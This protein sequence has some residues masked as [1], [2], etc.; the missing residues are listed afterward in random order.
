M[1]GIK[2][3]LKEA[4]N[5]AGLYSLWQKKEGLRVKC[6]F[7]IKNNAHG[8]YKCDDLRRIF[9]IMFIALSWCKNAS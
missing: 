4:S 9:S 2:H 6:I 8:K 7:L 3:A 5:K 1:T